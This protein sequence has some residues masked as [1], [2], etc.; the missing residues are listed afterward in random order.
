MSFED[1]KNFS[2]FIVAP[3]PSDPMQMRQWAQEIVTRAKN[4]A[5]PEFIRRLSTRPE[6]QVLCGLAQNPVTPEDVQLNLLDKND[7]VLDRAL[8]VNPNLAEAALRV[9]LDRI[10]DPRNEDHR[11]LSSIFRH[12]IFPIELLNEYYDRFMEEK[13]D[14]SF[15]EEFVRN[16]KLSK[17]KI[18]ALVM[19]GKILNRSCY[20]YLYKR[21][22]MTAEERANIAKLFKREWGME[23]ED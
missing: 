14:P 22:D 9:I 13:V 7:F 2:E 15:V 6:I 17:E 8:C 12:E 23:I 20:I 5:D 1:K 3:A 16:P 4:I 18:L 19:S 10:K 21:P 11:A